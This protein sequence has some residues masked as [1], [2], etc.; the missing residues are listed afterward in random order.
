[1]RLNLLLEKCNTMIIASFQGGIFPEVP[2]MSKIIPIYKEGNS[3][4]TGVLNLFQTPY[5]L[6][7]TL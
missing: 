2:K 5:P 6:K 1:M 7:K 4:N 3:C